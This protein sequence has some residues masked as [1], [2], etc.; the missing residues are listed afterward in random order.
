MN[1]KDTAK[2]GEL[3]QRRAE[4]IEQI[5]RLRHEQAQ[6]KAELVKL[7]TKSG[8]PRLIDAIVNCW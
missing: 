4:V 8:D 6:F 3:N 5:M 1:E 2:F 7:A